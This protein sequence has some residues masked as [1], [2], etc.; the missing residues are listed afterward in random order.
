[1]GKGCDVLM[2]I[3]DVLALLACG[4]LG[5]GKKKTSAWLFFHADNPSAYINPDMA[6]CVSSARICELLIVCLILGDC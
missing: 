6:R 5:S 1:M 3:S 2:G 4:A